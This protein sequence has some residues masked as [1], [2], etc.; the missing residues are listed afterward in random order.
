MARVSPAEQDAG[1]GQVTGVTTGRLAMAQA[2][3][4]LP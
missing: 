3:G 1:F 4:G 2:V